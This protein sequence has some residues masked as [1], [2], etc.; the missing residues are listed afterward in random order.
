MARM[1]EII[2]LKKYASICA[3]NQYDNTPFVMESYGGMGPHATAL[4]QRFS[5]TNSEYA[6]NEFLLHARR[7]LSVTLQSGNA[8]LTL[9]AM[10]ELTMRSQLKFPP[11][12]YEAWK[13][14]RTPSGYAAP[15][16]SNMLARRV[17]TAWRK[18][19]GA[20]AASN[21]DQQ[22]QLDEQEN[23]VQQAES[24]SSV[25]IIHSR[26]TNAFGVHHDADAPLSM[27][28]P[29]AD[30]ISAVPISP[31]C[32]TGPLVHLDFDEY[33][34]STSQPGVMQLDRR[35]TMAGHSGAA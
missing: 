8:N 9:L 34:A 35:V 4:L 14:K 3:V 24:D 26:R 1:R 30:P 27:P 11:A 29:T 33:Q 12:M 7:R 15:I 25:M 23:A 16:S 17:N 2:K 32:V 22:E 21:S 28:P 20:E 5:R 10:H 6:P 18:R 13:K 19:T 31:L